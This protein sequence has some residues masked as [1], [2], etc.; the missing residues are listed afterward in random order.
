MYPSSGA[1]EYSVELPH[2]S[3]CSVN[4]EDLALAS[5]MVGSGVFLM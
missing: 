5:I 4:T 3:Y 1:C 2:F